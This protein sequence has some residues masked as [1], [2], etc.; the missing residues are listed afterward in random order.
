[1]EEQIK[2][3]KLKK[4]YKHNIIK[5]IMAPLYELEPEPEQEPEPEPEQGL[6]YPA[7]SFIA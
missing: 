7:W 2:A 3:N 6:F 1:M 5:I 4:K